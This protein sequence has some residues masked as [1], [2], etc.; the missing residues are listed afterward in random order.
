MPGFQQLVLGA[1][2]GQ[3]QPLQLARQADSELADVH[4]LLYFAEAF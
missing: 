1:F 3:G 4:H 2:A